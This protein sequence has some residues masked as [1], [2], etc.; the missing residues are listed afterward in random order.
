MDAAKKQ[1]IANMLDQVQ[2]TPS[3]T[4]GA[5]YAFHIALP[6]VCDDGVTRAAKEYIEY[7]LGSPIEEALSAINLPERDVTYSFSDDETE[8]VILVTNTPQT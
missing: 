6:D 4:T 2:S 3:T 8:F 5:C 1:A 7:L